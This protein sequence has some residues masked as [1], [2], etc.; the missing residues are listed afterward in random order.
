[1]LP[2]FVPPEEI[3]SLVMMI[4][5]FLRKTFMFVKVF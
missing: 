5:P 4:I 2:K 1:M 3:K